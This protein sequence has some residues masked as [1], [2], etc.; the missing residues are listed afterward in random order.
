MYAGLHRGMSLGVLG[1]VGVRASIIMLID[2]FVAGRA[3]ESGGP[4]ATCEI[5]TWEPEPRMGMHFDND[6]ACVFRATTSY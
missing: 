2:T 1:S 3:E 5:T 6:A 4:T